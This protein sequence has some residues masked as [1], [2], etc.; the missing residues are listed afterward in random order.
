VRVGRGFGARQNLNI[1]SS[2]FTQFLKCLQAKELL[3]EAGASDKASVFGGATIAGFIAAAF[4]SVSDRATP[5]I[6][7]GR[8]R[9]SDSTARHTGA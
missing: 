8:H 9:L 5:S 4:R 7:L 1:T 2:M 6:A 3:K